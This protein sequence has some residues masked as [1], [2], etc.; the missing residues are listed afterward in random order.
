[1]GEADKGVRPDA[2]CR[3]S[4]GERQTAPFYAPPPITC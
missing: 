1:M 4:L 2:Y 3:R